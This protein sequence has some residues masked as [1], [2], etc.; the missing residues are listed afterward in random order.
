MVLAPKKWWS[1]RLAVPW[2][3]GRPCITIVNSHLLPSC[4]ASP[5]RRS[6]CPAAANAGGHAARRIVA[7]RAGDG[8]KPGGCQGAGALSAVVSCHFRNSPTG[9]QT[10]HGT[11]S[12]TKALPKCSSQVKRWCKCSC[13][14]AKCRPK[15]ST[16]EVQHE[17]VIL[18][19]LICGG[20]GIGEGA[21]QVIACWQ[22][23][24]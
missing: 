19:P 1:K 10:D 23:S 9:N 8:T 24:D 20:S 3:A 4:P 14:P 17:N 12:F 13:S 21:G 16:A 7:S 5:Q 2:P 11:G 22:Q 6:E 18:R 15:A